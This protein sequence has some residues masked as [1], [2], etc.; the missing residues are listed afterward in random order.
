MF[1]AVWNNQAYTRMNLLNT[2]NNS[3][4]TGNLNRPSGDL[5]ITNNSASM[6][7][8]INASNLSLNWTNGVITLQRINL[9]SVQI[10]GADL[11]I[12]NSS[13]VRTTHSVT[14]SLTG[15]LTIRDAGGTLRI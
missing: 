13:T 6:N 12:T 5:L 7:V 14:S 1:I 11:A 15:T 3:T 9:T 10:V 8:E 2:I 4:G